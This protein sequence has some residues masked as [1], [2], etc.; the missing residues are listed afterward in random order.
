MLGMS[1]EQLY[2]IPMDDPETLAAF[3]RADVTGIFQF[4]GRTM[5]LVTQELKPKTF[6][7][8]AAVNALARPGPL[9]SGSSGDYIAYRVNRK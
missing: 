3:E 9:H 4:E 1:L 6:M 7:D 5:K 2:D 8:L